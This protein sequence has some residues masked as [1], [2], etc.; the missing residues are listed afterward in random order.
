M[1]RNLYEYFLREFLKSAAFSAN[2]DEKKQ[3]FKEFIYDRLETLIPSNITK[4]KIIFAI[5]RADDIDLYMEEENLI[6]WLQTVYYTEKI[7]INIKLTPKEFGPIYW[8][9]M[10][11]GA[12]SATDDNS[13]DN[14]IYFVLNLLYYLLPCEIC[15]EHW[16][17]NLRNAP[18]I[19]NFSS[20]NIELIKW[21][22]E[23]KKIVGH[24]TNKFYSAPKIQ[25][26]IRKFLI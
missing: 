15:A 12:S 19:N 17:E 6:G 20:S 1:S 22:Y 14:Y 23:M 18:D 16:I 10:F 5:E 8:S 2:T 25:D 9:F 3:K 13:Q 11:Y 21:T 7:D 4:A 24:Q 26:I